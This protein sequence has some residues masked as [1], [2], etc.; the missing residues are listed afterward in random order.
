M[1]EEREADSEEEAEGEADGE[2]EGDFGRVG[3]C[4]DPGAVHHPDVVGAE[5]FGQVGL[6]EAGEDQLVHLFGVGFATLEAVVIDAFAGQLDAFFFG[7]FEGGVV[8]AFSADEGAAFG[9]EHGELEEGFALE[10]ATDGG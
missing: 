1:E 3:G 10:I 6:F 2:V 5:F 7:G 8:A 9:L 4:W